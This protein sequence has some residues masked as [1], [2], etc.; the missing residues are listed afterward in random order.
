MTLSKKDQEALAAMTGAT[1]TDASLG[2]DGTTG[3]RNLEPKKYTKENSRLYRVPKLGDPLRQFRDTIEHTC[4]FCGDIFTTYPPAPR[5]CSKRCQNDAYMMRRMVR[6]AERRRGRICEWCMK[7]FA[8]TR[9]H[10]RYCRPA[11]R[12]AAHRTRV[13]NRKREEERKRIQVD[14]KAAQWAR[15]EEL[16]VGGDH[17]TFWIPEPDGYLMTSEFIERLKEINRSREAEWEPVP[18]ECYR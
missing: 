1:V 10:A 13:R 14:L 6:L 8:S 18:P 7:A 11:C 3:I 9:M 17:G 2:M 4:A 15:Y 5:Y 16:R 12:Q